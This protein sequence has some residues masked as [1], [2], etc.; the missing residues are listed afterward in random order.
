MG[1][2]VTDLV[3]FENAACEKRL[4]GIVDGQIYS[5]FDDG[6]YSSR[7]VAD[8][9]DLFHPEEMWVNV[10]KVGDDLH[11]GEIYPY[12]SAAVITKDY[13]ELNYIGT[14]KLINK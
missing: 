8:D 6:S 5:W 10:Y 12:E 3:Y 4:F 9:L 11:A 7:L 14:F 2:R 13:Q 1:R